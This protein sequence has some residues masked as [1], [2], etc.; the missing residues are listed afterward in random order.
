MKL[1][2]SREV[3]TSKDVLVVSLLKHWC[4]NHEE[5][6]GELVAGLL[7]SRQ[8]HT[9]PNKRKRGGNRATSGAATSGVNPERVLAHLDQLRINSGNSYPLYALD[10]VQRALQQVQVNC[11]EAQK[12]TFSEL[13]ALAGEETEVDT[14]KNKKG[15]NSLSLSTSRGKTNT[16]GSRPPYKDCLLYT[17]DAADE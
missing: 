12:K 9:S 8:P 16:R 17:S 3:R 14:R 7:S 2:M 4:R 10:S 15:S 1:V 6:V 11:T 5:K 13:F